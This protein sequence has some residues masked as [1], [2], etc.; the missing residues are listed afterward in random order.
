MKFANPISRPANI[1]LHLVHIIVSRTNNVSDAHMRAC[2]R[3][4][5]DRSYGR[6]GE[7]GGGGGGKGEECFSS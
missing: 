2:M 6:E 3:I 1:R 4:T 5:C 7:G